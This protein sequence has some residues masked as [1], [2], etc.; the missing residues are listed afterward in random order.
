MAKI[1]GLDSVQANFGGFFTAL[2]GITQH[3]SQKYF[4]SSHIFIRKLYSL[5]MNDHC[6]MSWKSSLSLPNQ[7]IGLNKMGPY[8]IHLSFL[9]EPPEFFVGCLV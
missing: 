6:V 2:H 3:G 7:S 8:R 4:F 9:Q 1:K 5:L